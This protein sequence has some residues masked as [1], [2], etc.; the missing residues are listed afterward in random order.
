MRKLLF[1]FALLLLAAPA[2]AE[3]L[4]LLPR[5]TGALPAKGVNVL[6]LPT[7]TLLL[8]PSGTAAPKIDG[9]RHLPA[10]AAWYLFVYHMESD[11]ETG[12]GRELLDELARVLHDAGGGWLVV[13]APSESIEALDAVHAK[14]QKLVYLPVQPTPPAGAQS[15][16]SARGAI[17]DG[18]LAELDA[19]NYADYIRE[20]SGDLE[21][22]IDGVPTVNGNRYTYANT[23]YKTYDYFADRFESMGYTVQRQSFPAG[24]VTAQ[25]II[26]IKTGTVYPDSIV[27]VGGH[28]DAVAANLTLRHPAPGAEDNGSGAAG[29]LHLAEIFAGYNTEKTVHFVGFG[30]EEQGLW[31]SQHYVSEATQNGDHVVAALTMD[32]ISA[33]ETQFSV[34]VEGYQFA[35]P[36]MSLMVSNVEYYGGISA[37]KDYHAF[38]S[39]HIPFLQ[40]GVPCFLAIDED[41]DTYDHYHRSTDTFDKVDPSLGIAIL[42][43]VAGTLFDLTAPLPVSTEVPA[44]PAGAPVLAL[45]NEPNPFNPATVIRFELPDDSQV[46]LEILDL[47]GRRVRV[48]ADAVLSAGPHA[49]RWD[50]RDA[51]GR[52]VASGVYFYRL[53]AGARHATG[54]MALVR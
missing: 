1:T 51:S 42:K 31:G 22:L 35:D 48:L 23:I 15:L 8:T 18:L 27:V 9:I 38:G 52:G 34:I 11:G 32:M 54:R 30:A 33:W 37:R 49:I 26:A 21:Y 25:N 40:A 24:E 2:T 20:L 17:K 41:W 36:L 10:P 3:E 7:M 47:A 6:P 50:G 13:A 4:Y 12:H 14:K 45:H 16:S 44:G 19:I 29:V 28:I 43:G 53:D 39:D 46:T 5:D